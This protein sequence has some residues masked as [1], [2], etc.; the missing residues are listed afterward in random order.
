MSCS[1]QRQ[2]N[3]HAASVRCY[4]QTERV[5]L[6]VPPIIPSGQG[7]GCQVTN[8]LVSKLLLVHFFKNIQRMPKIVHQ[9]LSTLQPSTESGATRP[10][11]TSA[12]ASPHTRPPRLFRGL[13]LFSAQEGIHSPEHHLHLVR[14]RLTQSLIMFTRLYDNY[15]A[16]LDAGINN[17]HHHSYRSHD[18][19][20]R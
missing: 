12:P 19:T 16:Q 10:R 6:G 14:P 5:R 18:S 20:C 9:G 4:T 11:M 17:K 1:S 2:I 15:L 7:Q 3:L 13:T 8:V